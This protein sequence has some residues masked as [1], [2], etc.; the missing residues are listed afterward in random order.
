MA[1]ITRTYSFTDG[2]T[3]YGSQVDSE[4]AN[5][6]NTINSLD[7]G[8]TTWT[9]VKVTTL[10]PQAAVNMNSNRITSLGTPTTTGDAAQYPIT[11][12]QITAGTITTTQVASNTLTGSTANSGGSAGN[13]AQGT[14]S[15]PDL[16]ANA[17]TKTGQANDG[18]T[19][20]F[21]T[22]T[23][24]VTITTLGGPVLLM[25]TVTLALNA[26]G[27]NAGFEI[28][29]K[30]DG[31]SVAGS[32]SEAS[33][34]GQGVNVA[35][36]NC[37]GISIDTPAA[38]SHTYTCGYSLVTGSVNATGYHSLVAVELRA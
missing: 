7:Q 13:I 31:T 34:F 26:S 21:A 12:S 36:L 38:G 10:L 5:I 32:G 20:V 30:R 27:G 37:A 3:A 24:T 23:D 6:V 15:T 33:V 29:I 28:G 18:L 8:G 19:V 25:G 16:R 35:I 22:T 14:I 2:T 1:L 17:V 4:I 9:T 11:S